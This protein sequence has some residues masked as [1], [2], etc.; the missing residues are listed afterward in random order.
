MAGSLIKLCITILVASTVAAAADSPYGVE[1][2]AGC[3]SRP[4]VQA[5]IASRQ[6]KTWPE[7]KQMAGVS[8]EYKEVGSVKVCEQRGAPYYVVNV[9]TPSGDSKR[10]VLNAVDGSN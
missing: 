9:T 5:L 10:L 1:A 2:A 8:D 4:A 6:I 7:I 3:L